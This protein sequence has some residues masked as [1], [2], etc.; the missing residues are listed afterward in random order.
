LF[1]GRVAHRSQGTRKGFGT[2]RT[3]GYIK[4]RHKRFFG[5]I[6]EEDE[7]EDEKKKRKKTGMTSVSIPTE[8]S[9]LSWIPIR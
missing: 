3:A 9:V 2:P 1:N 6:H 4:W 8:N 7:D 5:L